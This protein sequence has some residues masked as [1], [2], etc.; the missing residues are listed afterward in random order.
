MSI[1]NLNVSFTL[2][3]TAGLLAAVFFVGSSPKTF[4]ADATQPI[5]KMLIQAMD[6]SPAV[7][8]AKAKVASA[9]AELYAAQMEVA[10]QIIALQTELNAN[11]AVLEIAELSFNAIPK[12]DQTA[13]LSARSA[14]INARTKLERIENELNSITKPLSPGIQIPQ[15]DLPQAKTNA[16]LAEKKPI[17][18]PQGPMAEKIRQTLDFA[19]EADFTDT[20]L[21]DILDYLKA[22]S[23]GADF[24]LDAFRLEEIDIKSDTLIN[25]R[26]GKMPL[27]AVLQA[28]EDRFPANSGATFVVRDYGI[29]FTIREHAEEMGFLTVSEFLRLNK[30]AKEDGMKS[31]SQKSSPQPATFNPPENKTD[32]IKNSENQKPM[33][34]G[35]TPQ[36]ETENSPTVK[37]LVPVLDSQEKPNEK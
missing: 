21:Q 13:L 9:Q 20:P 37:D 1:R 27:R 31:D 11:R 19:T 28:I 23:K 8:A 22:T 36:K 29:L 3:L 34:P 14:I 7:V 25:L 6:R 17:Q 12:E 16:I 18:I 33:L 15:A 5:D 24:V 2:C 4:A 10:K 32:K 30:P 35:A 26:L